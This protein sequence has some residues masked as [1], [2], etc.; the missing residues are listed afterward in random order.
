MGKSKNGFHAF[1]KSNLLGPWYIKG[2]EQSTTGKDSLI[3]L[4]HRDLGDLKLISSI[5]FG[6]KNLILDFS[7]ETPLDYL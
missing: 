2:S 3:P 1:P 4:I 5:N 7:K 6:F